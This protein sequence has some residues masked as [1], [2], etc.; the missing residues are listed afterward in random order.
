VLCAVLLIYSVQTRPAFLPRRSARRH[1]GVIGLPDIGHQTSPKIYRG[2]FCMESIFQG[3]DFKLI[4]TVEM[5]TRHPV[6]VL[7]GSEFRAI[8]NH[9]GVVTA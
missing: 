6:K 4:P 5:E 8:Y 2:F 1:S 9:C 7:F 3:N